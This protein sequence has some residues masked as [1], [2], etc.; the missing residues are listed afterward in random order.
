MITRK[1]IIPLLLEACPSFGSVWGP[2]QRPGED[3]VIHVAFGAFAGH[4]R[5]LYESGQKSEFRAFDEL[6]KRF[7]QEGDAE[8]RQLGVELVESV[9]F[10]LCNE[11]SA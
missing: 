7:Q 4:L 3:E 5:H 11:D 2:I 1:Q 9:Q 6:V 10:R 8:V